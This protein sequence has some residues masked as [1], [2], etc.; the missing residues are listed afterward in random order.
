MNHRCRDQQ[1]QG[2][3]VEQTV[4]SQVTN[5]TWKAWGAFCWHNEKCGELDPEAQRPYWLISS[6][7]ADSHVGQ[8][9]AHLRRNE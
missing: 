4:D 9:V 6:F 7:I 2:V 5:S 1:C 3:I 8:L